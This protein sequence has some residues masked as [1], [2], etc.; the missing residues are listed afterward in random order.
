MPRTPDV[1]HAERTTCLQSFLESSS[2]ASWGAGDFAGGLAVG[3]PAFTQAA[4]Y[5]E[6]LGV[7]LLLAAIP[8]IHE[9]TMPWILWILDM[10]AGAILAVGLMIFYRALAEGQMSVATPSRR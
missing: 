1:T 3:T 7:V 9:P 6:A 8:F 5:G 4:L 10:V 2:A